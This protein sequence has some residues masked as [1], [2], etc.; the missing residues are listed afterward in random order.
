[1][2]FPR[3]QFLTKDQ[4]QILEFSVLSDACCVMHNFQVPDAELFTE[5]CHYCSGDNIRN[6]TGNL[7]INVLR[8]SVRIITV[9]MEK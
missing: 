8:R 3:R 2:H 5:R 9:A 6:K 4:L 1:M 7:R